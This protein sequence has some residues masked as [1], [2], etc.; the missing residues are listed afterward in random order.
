MKN[1]FITL[2]LLVASFWTIRGQQDAQYTQYMYNTVAVNPAYAGSRGV[3]SIAALHRSQWVGLDGAPTTQTLNINSPI[4]DRVGLGLSIVNDEIGNGTNQDTYFDAVFSYTV[5]TSEE[6]KLSFGLKA[7]GHFL[8][9]DFNRLRNYDRSNAA[10]GQ[11]NIDNKF[12]PNFG[13]GVYYH[14]EQFYAGLSI[15]NFLETEHFDSGGNSNSY[16][17]Q[18]RMNW[19]L[20]TGYVFDIN[21]DLKL[22]PAL[23][24]KAVE[25]APLQADLS[26]T[27]LLN[28]TFSLGAAY[29]WDAA[30]SALVGFQLNEKLML[31]LAYDREITEL[32][33]TSFNDGSFEIFLRFEFLTRYK[34]ILAP[35]FF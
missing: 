12:S 27:V 30:M 34:N 26:A 28:D 25:G 35:R 31:G 20:I 29:R 33:S 9:I 3:L 4:S 14:T 17:A 5:P 23:L 1:L 2:F 21:P 7:G 22:K 24:F 10:V 6:G 8:N 13:A 15:P 11:T 19:Y 18:E 32:G 16:I